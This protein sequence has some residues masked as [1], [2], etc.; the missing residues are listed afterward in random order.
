M[1][2]EVQDRI[3]IYRPLTGPYFTFLLLMTSLLLPY[4]IEVG[5]LFSLSLGIPPYLIFGVFASSL[6]G[7]CL[8]FKVAEVE[9]IQPITYFEEVSFFGIRWRIPSVRYGKRKTLIAVNLGGALIPTAFSI[10]LLFNLGGSFFSYL[11][12]LVAFLVVALVVNKT[13]RPVRGLGIAVPTFVPPL[14]SALTAAI[15][16]PIYVKTNPFIVAYVAGTLGSLVGADLLNLDKVSKL[17]ASV[18]SIGGAGVFD[19]IYMSG[20][21]SVFLLWLFIL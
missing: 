10:Y 20:I 9:S 21:M 5:I 2:D 14:T 19:G 16:Y 1:E 7:S 17:G 4:F 3:L 12:V 13:A 6:F 15:L 8:N 11:K 18:V